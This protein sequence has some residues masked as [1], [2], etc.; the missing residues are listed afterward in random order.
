MMFGRRRRPGQGVTAA[1]P[2]CGRPD[3]LR[4]CIERLLVDDVI[5]RVLVWDSAPCEKNRALA[6]EFAIVSVVES[7]RLTGPAEARLELARRVE[8]DFTLYTD[9]DQ[10]ARNGA[11]AE[12]LRLMTRHSAVQ[13]LGGAL[14]HDGK[15]WNV[16]QHINFG[17]I[18]GELTVHKTFTH[19]QDLDRLGI[20]MIAAD[21][22]NP[23]MLV[24]TPAFRRVNF[25]PRFDFF[26]D[27]YDFGMQCKREGI[28]V[29]AT[30]RAVFEHD[31]GG[32]TGPTM[33]A[34]DRELDRQ[35]FMTK[36]GVRQIGPTGGGW[37]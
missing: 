11:V 20:D 1:V 9:D 16:A 18:G 33:R 4:E 19:P 10:Y 22:T 14:C 36:W 6:A 2:T 29:F 5:E 23:N 15:C 30:H 27:L 32:Y 21:I 3:K 7:E 35:K 28:Q 37:R 13:I 24:R 8:T 17:R 34:A 25:D 12:M 31:A 26:F